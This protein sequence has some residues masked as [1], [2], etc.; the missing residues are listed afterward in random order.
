MKP[1]THD[2]ISK[3]PREKE[4]EFNSLSCAFDKI[5]ITEPNNLKKHEHKPSTKPS[6][7]GK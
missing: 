6:I 3:K 4:Q 5:I 2:F 1:T 7:R